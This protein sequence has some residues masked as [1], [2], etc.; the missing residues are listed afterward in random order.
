MKKN[1]TRRETLAGA[2]GGMT[3]AGL[4]SNAHAR[5]KP[6]VHGGCDKVKTKGLVDVHAHFVPERYAAAASAAGYAQP[7]G[8]PGLPTWSEAAM[9]E[10]MD[11]LGVAC[12]VLSISSPGVHFGDAQQASALARLVNEQAAQLKRSH[13]GRIG[14]FASLPLPDVERTLVE[15]P[16]GLDD[17]NADGV[18][19]QSNSRGSYPGDPE[20]EPVLAML[21]ERAAV[22]FMHPTSPYCACSFS[23]SPALP[24]PILEFMFETT[25]AVC[26]LV[27]NDI[28][29]RFPNIK[30]IVPHAG[31]ALS[32]LADRIALSPTVLPGLQGVSPASV[33]AGLHS[34]YYDLAGTPFPRQVPALRT[35]A[36]PNKL[37][38]GSDWPFTPETAVGEVLSSIEDALAEEQALRAGVFYHNARALLPRLGLR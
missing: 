30:F 16:V 1:L 23:Q 2:I 38:Y 27:Y 26:S 17:L 36:D 25:R 12:S 24:A 37:L 6:W 35:F 20:L 33:M 21:D 31:A 28:P 15:I 14:F 8:M 18:V 29:Q 32:A 9:I 19:I 10:T 4:A 34:F 3:W 13:A 5:V 22:V 11:R 7:D